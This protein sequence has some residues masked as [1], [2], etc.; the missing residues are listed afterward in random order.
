MVPTFFPL[1]NFYVTSKNLLTG[2]PETCYIKHVESIQTEL[3]EILQREGLTPYAVAKAIGIDHASIYKSLT[4]GANP[5]WNTVKKVL[6]YLGY[7][8]KIIK[9]KEVKPI[10]SKPSRSRRQKGGL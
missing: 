3:K 6:D 10:K 8:F 9:R 2:Y 1:K 4:E 7:D 5:E